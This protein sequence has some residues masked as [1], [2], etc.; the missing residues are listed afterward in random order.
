VLAGPADGS[1]GRAELARPVAVLA[2]GGFLARLS[3]VHAGPGDTT[4]IRRDPVPYARFDP[5][6]RRVDAVGTFPDD[7]TFIYAVP[8]SRSVRPRAFGRE[9]AIAVRGDR[10]HVADNRAFQVGVLDAG[11]RTLRVARAAVEPVPVDETAREAWTERELAGLTSSFLRRIA[12]D[13]IRAMPFPDSM[14]YH[15][16]LVVADDGESWLA[17]Y[18]PDADEP[19][20]WLVFGPDGRVVARVQTPARFRLSQVGTDFVIGVARDA[21]DV[22]RV[23]VYR[24]HR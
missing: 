8:G 12:E 4:A 18:S 11:G 17:R 1:G 20:R 5:D 9:T 15:G 7:E 3:D 19:T 10:I 24:L 6:G 21:L 23:V 13:A 14:P 16:P 22:E 2:D